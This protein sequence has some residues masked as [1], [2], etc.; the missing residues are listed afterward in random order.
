MPA[1]RKLDEYNE[2][3]DATRDHGSKLR[4][5]SSL[6]I[7]TYRMSNI[8]LGWTISNI[9]AWLQSALGV[10]E[11]NRGVSVRTFAIN[12]DRRSKVATISFSQR[13]SL[14]DQSSSEWQFPVVANQNED[15]GARHIARGSP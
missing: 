1:K 2:V 8:P 15:F 5:E 9:D 4:K 10:G 3:L 7:K 11:F 6:S 12:H 13:P 14:L